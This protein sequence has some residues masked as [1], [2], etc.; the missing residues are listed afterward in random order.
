MQVS[1]AK[2]FFHKFSATSYKIKYMKKKLLSKKVWKTAVGASKKPK[3]SAFT[4]LA[5]FKRRFFVCTVSQCDNEGYWSKRASGKHMFNRMFD[6]EMENC[7]V[8]FFLNSFE[9]TP[10]LLRYK[11]TYTNVYKEIFLKLHKTS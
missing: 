8:F 2:I 4:K 9:N 10:Q 11:R 1:T 6:E 3:L 7:S 5:I